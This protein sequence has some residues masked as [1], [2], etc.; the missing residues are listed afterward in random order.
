MKANADLPLRVEAVVIAGAAVSA[1]PTRLNELSARRCHSTDVLQDRGCW[2]D[3]CGP[4]ARLCLAMTI[5]EAAPP[6]RTAADRRRARKLS[7][8]RRPLTRSDM[9]LATRRRSTPRSPTVDH[10]LKRVG[11]VG[12]LLEAQPAKPFWRRSP[13]GPR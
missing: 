1:A 6:D 3:V 9:E 7:G 12:A 5:D 13:A 8:S 11:G 2:D 4:P 10:D